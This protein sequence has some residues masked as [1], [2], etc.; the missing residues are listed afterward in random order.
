MPFLM[1]RKGQKY[2][3]GLT[4]I[5]LV[6][7]HI[8]LPYNVAQGKIEKLIGTYLDYG[9]NVVRTGYQRVVREDKFVV[10]LFKYMQIVR[11]ATMEGSVGCRL[12][13]GA[14]ILPE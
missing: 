9:D 13:G 8:V 10:C 3:G 5:R 11:R 1:F 6:Q 7:T 14:P 2:R 12:K 4:P